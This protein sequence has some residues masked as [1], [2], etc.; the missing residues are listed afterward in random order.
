MFRPPPR[1]ARGAGFRAARLRRR[2]GHSRQGAGLAG[3]WRTSGDWWTPDPWSRDE[4]DIALSDGALYRLSVACAA[5][6]WKAAMTGCPY[7]EP[8]AQRM[9]DPCLRRTPRPLRRSASSKAR[10]CPRNWPAPARNSACRPWPWWTATASTARRVFTWPR[11][12]PACARTSARKSPAPTASPI[13]CWRKR[14][15]ATETCAA[16]SPA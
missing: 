10:P 7:V 12:R 4:W 3:P 13:P 15:K 2:R 9:T 1:R 6:S 16:W 14:A 5:G 8:R 11:R